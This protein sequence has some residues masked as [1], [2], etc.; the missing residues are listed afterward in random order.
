MKTSIVIQFQEEGIHYWPT[1]A[2][3]QPQVSYL[4]YPH[5]HVFHFKAMKEVTEEDRE[6]E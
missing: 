5:R 4:Q 1:A 3:E 6:I 2:A